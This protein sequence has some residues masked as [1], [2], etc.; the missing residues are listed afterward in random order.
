MQSVTEWATGIASQYPRLRTRLEAH[1]GADPV[2]LSREKFAFGV[3]AILDGLEARLRD[4]DRD[5]APDRDGDREP[6][7]G[8]EPEP[9]AAP[10]AIP[11]AERE[12]EP[13]PAR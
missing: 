13:R 1:Q 10:V 2:E 8:R 9:A 12:P 5:R 3:E 7:G 4:R 6:D 11:D